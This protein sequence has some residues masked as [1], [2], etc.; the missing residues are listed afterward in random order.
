ML[1]IFQNICKNIILSN[2][3]LN[4]DDSSKNRERGAHNVKISLMTIA[5]VKF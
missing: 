5:T 1:L 3:S 4:S 2:F